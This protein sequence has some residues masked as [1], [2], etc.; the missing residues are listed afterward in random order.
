HEEHRT[1]NAGDRPE[2]LDRPVEASLRNADAQR[3]L[4]VL[5]PPCLELLQRSFDLLAAGG[6]GFFG[7]GG[8]RPARIARSKRAALLLFSLPTTRDKGKPMLCHR[9]RWRRGRPEQVFASSWPLSFN[10]CLRLRP[11]RSL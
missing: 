11:R 2:F 4:A 1:D 7:F 9:S 8:R 5:L 3:H 6:V 10:F